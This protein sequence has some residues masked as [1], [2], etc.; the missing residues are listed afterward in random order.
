[1]AII[2]VTRSGVSAANW[3]AAMLMPAFHPGSVRPARKYSS[4]FREEMLRERKAIARQYARKAPTMATSSVDSIA[5]STSDHLGDAAN[6][7]WMSP[8]WE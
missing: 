4:R 6:A 5:Q 3:V 7:A 8:T 2:P 1:M